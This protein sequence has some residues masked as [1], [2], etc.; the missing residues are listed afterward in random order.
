MTTMKPKINVPKPP[1]P[2]PVLSALSPM[3]MR[4]AEDRRRRMMSRLG[5]EGTI[6]TRLGGNEMTLGL[7]G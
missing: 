4:R 6:L 2:A 3:V 5:R 7:V 1:A